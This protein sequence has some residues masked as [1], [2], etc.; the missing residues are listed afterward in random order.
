MLVLPKEHRKLFKNPFGELHRDMDTVI[1]LLANR[2]VYTVGDVV[3]H[4]LQKRGI[5]PA[6]AVIDGQTMRLPC[7][8]VPD[9][10]GERIHVIN[11]PGTL[12]D[13]LIHALEQAVNRTPVMIVVEGEED[14][15]VIPLVIAAPD[16]AVILY[17]QPH[18]GVVIR[19]VDAGAKAAARKLLNHFIRT[20]A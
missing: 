15:A 2:I 9:L 17:G 18:E 6:I 7:N 11:P 8:R 4:N 1:P 20:N 12:T 14:L 3:T 13:D 19:M 16:G 10:V 5:I